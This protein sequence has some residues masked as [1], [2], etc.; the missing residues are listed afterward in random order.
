MSWNHQPVNPLTVGK[1]SI[2]IFMKGTHYEASWNPL[3]FQCF[4]S[5]PT[6]KAYGQNKGPRALK[7]LPYLH[8]TH[9]MKVFF[10]G[11]FSPQNRQPWTRYVTIY[12]R[13]IQYYKLT[14][15]CFGVWFKGHPGCVGYRCCF[16]VLL[17]LQ[18]KRKESPNILGSVLENLNQPLS[19]VVLGRWIGMVLHSL[20][21]KEVRGLSLTKA[22]L[23]RS[24]ICS[25]WHC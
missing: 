9:R 12:L 14:W 13:D 19:P 20:L 2:R 17:G 10:P 15:A 1:T 5:G 18:T 16:F 3:V 4:F 25:Q 23:K 6:Q 8:A 21:A 7:G 22:K 11:K 24:L